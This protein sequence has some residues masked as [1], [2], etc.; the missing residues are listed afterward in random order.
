MEPV[1]VATSISQGEELEVV[2]FKSSFTKE[3]DGDTG[4]VY[5]YQRWH[6]P[7]TG[8]FM[9]SAPYPVMMEHRYGFAENRPGLMVDPDGRMYRYSPLMEFLRINAQ[10]CPPFNPK[11]TCSKARRTPTGSWYDS[12]TTW[13]SEGASA[14]HPGATECFREIVPRDSSSLAGAQCCY[15]RAGNLI[16]TGVGAGTLDFVAP[17]VEAEPNGQCINAPDR[18][19][20]HF[21]V[22][23]V[24]WIIGF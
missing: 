3:L 4:L 11:S 1:I 10:R 24:P 20:G 15:D 5:M 13:C 14:A 23:V 12:G 9:S 18:V 22:D 21:N 2:H 16:T 7:E 6:A 17:A 19:F 8:T